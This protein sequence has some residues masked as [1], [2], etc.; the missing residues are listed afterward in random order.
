MDKKILNEVKRNRELMGLNESEIDEQLG[1]V[2][3]KGIE[4][5]KEFIK[6]LLKK[7]KEENNIETGVETD[8]ESNNEI[9]KSGEITD[10]EK[11]VNLFFDTYKDKTI[12]FVR[13]P[14]KDIA[15]SILKTNVK[16]LGIFDICKFS[17]ISKEDGEM[18]TTSG[19]VPA[20]KCECEV[21]NQ[22]LEE[23]IL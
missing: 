6:N 19:K 14:M 1:S 16:N 15:C 22:E 3:K 8:T 13:S 7:N 10:S 11:N 4:K 5:G 21:D 20:Y 12:F 18:E 9:I 2:I 23:N 17:N